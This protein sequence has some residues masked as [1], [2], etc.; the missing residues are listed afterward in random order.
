MKGA[1][2]GKKIVIKYSGFSNV[3]F[4]FL[5]ENVARNLT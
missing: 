3:F 2:T 5:T 1:S 4:M